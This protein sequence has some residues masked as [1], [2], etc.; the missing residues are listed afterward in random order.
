MQLHR[1]PAQPLG[2]AFA[3]KKSQILRQYLCPCHRRCSPSL[4]HHHHGIIVHSSATFPLQPHHHTNQLNSDPELERLLE[5]TKEAYHPPTPLPPTPSSATLGALM[6]YLA[7]LALGE[8]QLYWRVAGAMAALILYVCSF[9]V[10]CLLPT[11][12]SSLFSQNTLP[13]SI[14]SKQVQ[15]FWIISA[16]VFQARRRRPLCTSCYYNHHHH[17]HCHHHRSHFFR[18]LSSS[19]C[20]LQRTPTPPL[21]PSLS[22]S[23]SPRVVLRLGPLP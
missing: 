7:R 14:K 20:P 2:S 6:P 22:S 17:C 13:I 21:H 11:C 4:P 12:C 9:F 10:F 5:S 15:G 18:P 8:G 16:C 3:P 23:W 1:Y 19:L